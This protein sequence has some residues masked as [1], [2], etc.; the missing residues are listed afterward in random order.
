MFQTASQTEGFLHPRKES[1]INHEYKKIVVEEIFS[2]ISLTKILITTVN[3]QAIHSHYFTSTP[4]SQI[5]LL[6]KI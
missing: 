4:K 3:K 1:N 5:F 6:Q 2:D